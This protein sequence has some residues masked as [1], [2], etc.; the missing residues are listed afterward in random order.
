MKMPVPGE[1][2]K[3]A[4]GELTLFTE[5]YVPRRSPSFAAASDAAW[6]VLG[7][8]VDNIGK[9]TNYDDEGLNHGPNGLHY[10][11]VKLVGVVAKYS[12]GGLMEYTTHW[13]AFCPSKYFGPSMYEPAEKSEVESEYNRLLTA[14]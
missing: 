10:G 2:W 14:A 8:K 3:M 13:G 9:T 12:P 4:N 7:V 6:Q 1:V 11:L 5:D